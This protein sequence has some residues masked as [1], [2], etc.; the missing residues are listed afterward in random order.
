[1]WQKNERLGNALE[2]Q[3]DLRGALM[4]SKENKSV[5]KLGWELCREHEEMMPRRAVIEVIRWYSLLALKYIRSVEDR[6]G[7]GEEVLAAL[8]PKKQGK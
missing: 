3:G 2:R 5:T 8:P 6:R 7:F 1:M 4:A